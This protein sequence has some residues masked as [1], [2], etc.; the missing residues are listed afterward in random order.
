MPT[1]KMTITLDSYGVID[2]VVKPLSK[3]SGR[4]YV[5]SEWIGKKVRVVL[6]EEPD[7]TTEKED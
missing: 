6:I 1:P 2:K 5:P 7:E 4:V 3:S